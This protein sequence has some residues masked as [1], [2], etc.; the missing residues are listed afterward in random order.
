MGTLPMPWDQTYLS[1]WFAFLAEVAARY[2][3]NPAFRMI[4]A[5]GPTSVSA[6]MSLPNRGSDLAQWAALGYTPAR[7][8]AAWQTVFAEFARLFPRQYISLSLVPGL[9]LGSGGTPDAAEIDELPASILAEG[10]RDVPGFALMDSGLTAG[11]TFSN[12]YDLVRSQSGKVVTGF[13][14]STAAT[15]SPG[16]MGDAA[17]PVHALALTL[18]RGVAAH[19][20]FLEVYQ[21]DVINPTMQGVLRTTQTELPH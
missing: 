3:N 17:D 8:A 9:A 4:A 20:D 18:E 2:R 1:R 12:I 11:T 7:Y 6:E 14:L 13:Q 10:L 15:N 5:D 19:V 21:P 16:P